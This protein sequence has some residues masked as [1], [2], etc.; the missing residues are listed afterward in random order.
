MCYHHSKENISL[1]ES[2][3][4]VAC[5]MAGCVGVAG[6]CVIIK[7]LK[8]GLIL[9]TVFAIVIFVVIYALIQLGTKNATLYEIVKSGIEFINNRV[10]RK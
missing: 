7:S 9:E 1:K 2:W 3:H 5:T 8:L 4:S 10:K 6:V